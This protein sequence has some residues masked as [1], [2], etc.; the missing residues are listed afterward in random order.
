MNP[1]SKSYYQSDDVLHMAQSLLG[2]VIRSNL[3]GVEVTG[4]IV[5][6]EAYRS[7]DDKG[8]HAYPDKVT[9]RTAI[10]YA[11]GGNAYIYLCYG[12]HHLFNVITGP[13]ESGHVVLIRAVELMEGVEFA[14]QRRKIKAS[15]LNLTNGPGKWTQAF[16]I[17][18]HLNNSP[19]YKRSG[20]INILDAPSIP[21]S[22]IITSPRVGIA[23]AQEC[24]HWPWRYRIVDNAWTSK[25]DQVSY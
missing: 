8:S 13:A 3:D 10:Q 18:T 4:R 22:Q 25:P 21:K 5:E 7:T 6:T 20:N 24:A 12:I 19:L 11:S 17:T 14:R 9:K 23:Y 2:K 1:L 15:D 16:G